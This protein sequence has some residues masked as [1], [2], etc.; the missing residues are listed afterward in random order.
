MRLERAMKT[1]NRY[2]CG[3][4]TK[5]NL[6]ENNVF[7]IKL[8]FHLKTKIQYLHSFVDGLL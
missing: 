1:K 4:L 2:L 3:S 8:L 5:E 7:K 6:S